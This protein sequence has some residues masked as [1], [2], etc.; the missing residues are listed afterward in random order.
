MYIVRNYRKLKQNT[1]IKKDASLSAELTGYIGAAALSSH[2][3][4]MHGGLVSLDEFRAVKAC[5]IS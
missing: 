3:Q 4:L 1:T 2:L 5:T